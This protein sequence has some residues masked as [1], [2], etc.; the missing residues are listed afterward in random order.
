MSNGKLT[1]HWIKGSNEWLS[2]FDIEVDVIVAIDHSNGDVVD[3]DVS[4]QAL[5]DRLWA[6]GWQWEPEPFLK[7]KEYMS[8]DQPLSLGT[9]K[10]W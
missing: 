2:E 9:E 1:L 5:A 3:A 8:L 6:D 7:G 4:A 10:N